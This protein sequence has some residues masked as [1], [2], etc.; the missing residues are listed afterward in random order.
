MKNGD[1]CLVSGVSG[2]LG[3]WIAKDL[4]EKGF[5]VRGTVRSLD[6]PGRIATLRQLL[7][8]VELVAADL[9]QEQGWAE[10]VAGCQWV[11]HVASPQ[12]VK[13]E[14][15][16]TGGAISGTQYVLAA[17]FAEP[18]VQK[19]VMTSSEAAI[20]YGHPRSKQHIDET[21]WTDLN[22]VG[23]KA[24]YFRSKTLA[25]RLAWEWAADPAR[26][27]RR[28]PVATVNPCFILGPSLVPWGRYSLGMLSDIAQGK[29][30]LMLNMNLHIVDVRD[31]ARMHIAVM[32]NEA[33]NGRRHLSMG[34][35][36]SFA[37]LAHSITRN[38]GSIGFAP[39]ARV[40]P[41]WLAR[42]MAMLSS[43]VASIYSHVGNELHYETRSPGVFRYKHRDVDGIVQDS[44]ESMLQHQWL[45]PLKPLKP[46]E[47]QKA[48]TARPEPDAA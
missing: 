12:A 8:G 11:F 40:A 44:M 19:V 20:A 42:L 35:T 3:S 39:K 34:T 2:Y 16:R 7:P 4:L 36:G 47:P 46:Q 24:D 1:L 37:A 6:D 33:S 41:Q 29:M 26:N 27:P 15:D 22:A 13:S 25:E 43:D 45:K 28:I 14:H 21:D 30:P 5:R 9:R 18:S 38:F 10:A 17:A 32:A 23:Q 48:R 31:C